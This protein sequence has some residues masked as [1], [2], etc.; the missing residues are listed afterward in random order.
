MTTPVEEQTTPKPARHLLRLSV[1]AMMLL[2]VVLA[3]GL[4]WIVHR[5]RVQRLAV[6][7]I[8][9]T[10][11]RVIYEWGRIPG[12]GL[13]PNGKPRAP[14]WLVERLGVDYFGNVALVQ[15]GKQATDAEMEHV[16]RLSR[17][18][19]INA[20]GTNVTDAGATHLRGLV[21][22]DHINLGESRVT[23][24]CL[25]NF[26]GLSKLKG[27]YL[28]SVPVADADLANVASLTNL[29]ILD[30]NSTPVTDAGLAHL[31]RLV[32]LKQLRL[33]S[34]GVTGPGLAHLG[35]MTQLKWLSLARRARSATCRPSRTYP[36]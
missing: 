23:G 30:L 13:D 17:L 10:G 35:G 8:E 21:D 34:T 29:E 20:H 15:L 33:Q 32:K 12:K 28:D 14:R 16:G 2:V 6:E 22:L 27:L 25:A 7:A 26:R 19:G 24:A 11:G 5:A 18:E 4:G 3:L 9:K 36:A 31:Q 1:R